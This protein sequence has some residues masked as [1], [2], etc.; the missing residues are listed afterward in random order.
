M[1]PAVGDDDL[2][3][4]SLL[5]RLRPVQTVALLSGG[6]V[7]M[8]SILTVRFTTIRPLPSVDEEGPGSVS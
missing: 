2:K 7:N 5:Q 6:H 8:L 1:T 3:R 4:A